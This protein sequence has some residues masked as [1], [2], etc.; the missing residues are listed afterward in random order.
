[1]SDCNNITYFD[2]IPTTHQLVSKT[3]V[4]I[5]SS[6][7]NVLVEYKGLISRPLNETIELF[8]L[9]HKNVDRK[10]MQIYKDDSKMS[11]DSDIDSD[12]IKKI[13]LLSLPPG[14]VTMIWIFLSSIDDQNTL[15]TGMKRQSRPARR[16]IFNNFNDARRG[17]Y[18]M[19]D[20]CM[21]NKFC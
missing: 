7:F 21:N 9:C 17:Q 13:P 4:E 5:W 2:I 8:D 20:L 3:A 16:A 18:Y 6:C 15:T 11:N 1:M 10:R 12:L 19:W 14:K